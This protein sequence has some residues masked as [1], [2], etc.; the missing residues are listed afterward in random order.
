MQPEALSAEEQNEFLAL[1][2]RLPEIW[3]RPQVNRESKKALL[4]SLIDKV[5]LPAGHA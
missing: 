4:R 1:G 2:A 3:Q 5:I